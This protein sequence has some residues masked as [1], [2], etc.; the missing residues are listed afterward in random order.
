[1][2]AS[3]N[4]TSNE[5]TNQIGVTHFRQQEVVFQLW[6]LFEPINKLLNFKAKHIENNPTRLQQA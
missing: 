3:Y 6:T 4:Q 2:Q 5:S 1:M